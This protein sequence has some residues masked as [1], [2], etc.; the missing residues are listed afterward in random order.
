MKRSARGFASDVGESSRKNTQYFDE[1]HPENLPAD[2]TIRSIFVLEEDQVWSGLLDHNGYP[3]F[4]EKEPVG[5]R[6]RKSN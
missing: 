2:P 1:E 5:F 4:R 6:I 3:L